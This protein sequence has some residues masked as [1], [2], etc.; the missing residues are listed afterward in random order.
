M[1]AA[2]AVTAFALA[3]CS[4]RATSLPSEWLAYGSAWTADISWTATSSGTLDGQI[5]YV[6]ASTASSGDEIDRSSVGF[7]GIENEGKITINL[8]SPLEDFFDAGTLTGTVNETSLDLQGGGYGGTA[9]FA[10]AGSGTFEKRVSSISASV[11]AQRLQQ[12]QQAQQ[13]QAAQQAS[14]ALAAKSTLESTDIPAVNAALSKVQSDRNVMVAALASLHSYVS[15]QQCQS[16]TNETQ[17]QALSQGVVTD[18]NNLSE[19]Q[20]TLTSATQAAGADLNTAGKDPNLDVD[21]ESDAL[22]AAAAA[23]TQA[24]SYGNNA[25]NESD[26][27]LNSY[28]ALSDCG[29]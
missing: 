18:S 14:S 4:S 11:D 3:G 17:V 6:S 29:S 26:A 12:A 22:K 8:T 20:S 7:T 27:Y 2:V 19:D 15:A 16:S 23:N 5:Q 1:A 25:L 10:P 24:T 9:E 28:G 21:S 13:Q